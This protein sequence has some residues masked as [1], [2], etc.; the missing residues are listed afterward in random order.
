LL[1]QALE[2]VRS[3]YTELVC[4]VGYAAGL[5]EDF[6]FQREDELDAVTDPAILASL[7]MLGI[8]EV[9]FSNLPR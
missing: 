5:Q 6:T 8:R 4:H 1:R 9:A 3:G 2:S 7:S